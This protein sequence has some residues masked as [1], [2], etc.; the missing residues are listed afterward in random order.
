MA[1]HH[2]QS[3]QTLAEEE[4]ALQQLAVTL[5]NQT[6]L[7]INTLA[8]QLSTHRYAQQAA[9]ELTIACLQAAV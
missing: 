2:P 6:I 5:A 3:V 4:P 9:L 7:L 8:P 1:Q